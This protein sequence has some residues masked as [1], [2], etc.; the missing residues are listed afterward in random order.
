MVEVYARR[1]GREPEPLADLPMPPSLEIVEEKDLSLAVRQRLQ[2]RSQKGTHLCSLRVAGRAIGGVVRCNF[3]WKRGPDLPM[4]VRITRTVPHDLEEPAGEARGIPALLEALENHHESV[5]TDIFGVR[6]LPRLGQRHG[7][8]PPQVAADQH[9]VRSGVALKG[10][11][12]QPGILGPSGIPVGHLQYMTIEV[13]KALKSLEEPG[14]RPAGHYVIR[15]VPWEGILSDWRLNMTKSI[16]CGKVNPASG[17][18]HVIRAENEEELMRL[19]AKHAREVHSMEPT[20]ELIAKVK[21]HI[22]EG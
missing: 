9:L 21:S 19:V 22:E 16:D 18:E 5:L 3:E 6:R 11:L 7:I 20:P 12:D 14:I 13:R 8:G 10:E 15:A 4:A 1:T 2:S 17:C